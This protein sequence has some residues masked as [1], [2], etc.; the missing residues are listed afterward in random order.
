MIIQIGNVAFEYQRR[1]GQTHMKAFACFLAWMHE[2][3][4][5]AAA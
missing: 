4:E 5:D 1:C 3:R 2:L